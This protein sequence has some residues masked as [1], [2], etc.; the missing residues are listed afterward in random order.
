[1]SPSSHYLSIQFRG[2]SPNTFGI[3]TKVFLYI[4]GKLFFQ[5]LQT[6][7]G[8]M[9]SGEPILHF[10]LGA[11]IRADS[12]FVLW[13][14]NT[15]Q[16]LYDIPTNQK[17]LVKYNPQKKDSIANVAVFINSLL[18]TPASSGFTD[19]TTQSGITYTHK[20]NTEFID[21]NRQWFLPHRLSTPGPALAVAD[22]NGDGLEDFF[23]GGGRGQ[24]GT[25]FLQT[26]GGHFISSPDS[27]TFLADRNC[28]D[29][30]A[31]FF[32]ANGDGFAD[33][34]VASGGNEY[35]GEMPEL[36]DRLYFNDGKGHF[37]KSAGLPALFEN[38]SV[39]CAADF[40][41]DGDIDIFVGGRANANI[42]GMPPQS[43]LLRNDGKGNFSIVTNELAKGLSNIGMIT[44]AAWAD[45][46]HDGWPDLLLAGEW[47]PPILF[48]NNHGRL[49]QAPLT[50]KDDELIGWWS[51]VKIVDV[52]GDSYPDILLGNIGTNT[53]FSAS[54]KYP[55]KMYV[56]DFSDN[57][58]LLQLL[59]IPKNKEYY[60]F[61]TKEN[62]EE[63]LPYL[64]REFLSYGKMAGK[65][66]EEIFGNRLVNSAKYHINT[67]ASMLLLNNGKGH[68]KATPLPVAWQWTTIM[69]FQP[70]DFNGDGKMDLLTAGNFYGTMPYEGR[71]DALPLSMA[72]GDGSGVFKPQLPL[73]PP[74]DTLTGEVRS[75]K[76]IHLANGKKAI[77]AGINN[78][79][80]KLFQF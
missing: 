15:Y 20:E 76:I 40:D 12:L 39:V 43:Y 4:A 66:T 9:S 38:K 1:L 42:Y 32:D 45:V 8:F 71:Y 14:D 37:T 80:L 49:E 28:E 31:L 21:F 23:V 10:G 67:L 26:P 61:L 58:K 17:L 36:K 34:Y 5:E 33:L 13:P 56:G 72:Y 74:F 54:Y 16:K 51:S 19:I 64:K 48:I 41:K 2:K 73:L 53:K 52:N 44:D 11:G 27:A 79:P 30:D 18:H 60:P 35:A 57:K 78:A 24:G 77:I 62:L 3:G 59:S 29:V 69:D 55:L 7:H 47:L 6:V 46:D 25:L 63:Q 70:F 22:V 75:L 68:F 65:T 50:E